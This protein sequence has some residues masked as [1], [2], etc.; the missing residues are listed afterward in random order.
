[1]TSTAGTSMHCTCLV[2]AELFTVRSL[3]GA[4]HGRTGPQMHTCMPYAMPVLGDNE[5]QHTTIYDYC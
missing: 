5:P 2:A 3:H 1:M 4:V